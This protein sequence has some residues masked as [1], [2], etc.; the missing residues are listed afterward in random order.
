MIIYVDTNVIIDLLAKREP[1]YEN[2]YKLFEIIANEKNIIGYTSVKSITDIYYIMHRYYHD[3]IRTMRSINNLISLLYVTDNTDIDLLKSFSSQV[4]DFE[5][6]LI[7]ELSARHSMSYIVTR[8]IK[9][10]K[11]SKVQAITPEEF[12][13]VL[14]LPELK[15]E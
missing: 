9:D 7:D 2:A 15:T 6:S 14:A 5:D 13:K 11:G 8:N 1:F 10:Y 4:K 12:L 3:K